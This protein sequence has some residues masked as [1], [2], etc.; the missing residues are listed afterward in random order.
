MP[1]NYRRSNS[2]FHKPKEKFTTLRSRSASPVAKREP[3]HPVNDY[4]KRALAAGLSLKD[5]QDFS[6][7]DWSG[8][9]DTLIKL[10]ALE[11]RPTNTGM[12]ARAYMEDLADLSYYEVIAY[13]LGL[14]KDA[15]Q[16]HDW[17]GSQN[18]DN[19][20]ISMDFIQDNLK[21]VPPEDK[22][23]EMQSRMNQ[24]HG[25]TYHAIDAMRQGLSR[26][27]LHGHD[28]SGETGEITVEFLKKKPTNVSV[29]NRM[30]QIKGLNNYQIQ[31]MQMGLT[32]E[33]LNDHDWSGDNGA[34]T[35]QY[36]QDN[37]K[38]TDILERMKNI[39][40][41]NMQEIKL[42]YTFYALPKLDRN[43]QRQKPIE[44]NDF[45]KEECQISYVA[46]KKS[47]QPVLLRGDD[48]VYKFFDF[49][50]LA[51]WLENSDKNPVTNT[52]I[53]L[54]ELENPQKGNELILR[55]K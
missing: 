5:L 47:K 23:N 8:S 41:Y 38:S 28:W 17:S 36:L 34:T 37:P 7:L 44:P 1:D 24:I 29:H 33:A 26:G 3:K 13:T 22:I 32:K 39:H 49:K 12:S 19:G 20:K 50:A 6:A 2:N 46:F 42:A 21:N 43:T 55:L 27:G 4:H 31:A 11:N 51:E 54:D 18:L 16:G 45:E 30:R 48:G 10:Q 40:G 14:E 9:S 52:Q 35:I 25:L 53:N 15:L